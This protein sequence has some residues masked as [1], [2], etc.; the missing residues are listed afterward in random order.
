MIAKLRPRVFPACTAPLS[1]TSG[2]AYPIASGNAATM[3]RIHPGLSVHSPPPVVAQS[4]LVDALELEKYPSIA[5]PFGVDP[6]TRGVPHGYRAIC[7][8]IPSGFLLSVCT[9]SDIQRKIDDLNQASV[10]LVP[11]SVAGFANA[12]DED[13]LRYWQRSRD[14][15][16]EA[17]S[18]LQTRLCLMPVRIKSRRAPYDP[19]FETRR[20]AS[21]YTPIT[22]ADGWVLMKYKE[23]AALQRKT[24]CQDVRVSRV[25]VSISAISVCSSFA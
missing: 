13:V 23:G 10:I 5:T 17:Q 9:E 1:P 16:D 8:R 20:V 4:P 14:Q 7:R 3:T 2:I 12:S 25:P 22:S 11:Q 18:K 24:L 6:D 19:T 15:L 21:L